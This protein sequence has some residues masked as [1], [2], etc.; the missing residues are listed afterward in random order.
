M[1]QSGHI[2]CLVIIVF[3]VVVVLYYSSHNKKV[4]H[5]PQ[6]PQRCGVGLPSCMGLRCMNGYCR[7]DVAPT[8][9]AFSDL[10][11]A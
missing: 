6:G 1:K 2:L 5:V 3:V 9:P 8:F 11:M 4:E 7:S 10:R